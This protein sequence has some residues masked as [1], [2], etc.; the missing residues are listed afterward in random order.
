MHFTIPLLALKLVE[1]K[2]PKDAPALIRKHKDDVFGPVLQKGPDGQKL[3]QARTMD[4]VIEKYNRFISGRIPEI[5][6]K[7][8]LYPME[9]RRGEMHPVSLTKKDPDFEALFR[10]IPAV[11]SVVIFR[12]RAVGLFRQFLGGDQCCIQLYFLDIPD[13]DATGKA[14]DWQRRQDKAKAVYLGPIVCSLDDIQ[15]KGHVSKDGME[16]VTTRVRL[17]TTCISLNPIF[18]GVVGPLWA[19][20]NGQTLLIVAEKQLM[21]PLPVICAASEVCVFDQFTKEELRAFA[22]EMRP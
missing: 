22:Q 11:G 16:L 1:E 12:N 7:D 14:V 3:I 8:Y 13:E 15:W 9:F 19:A 17:G 20:A 10:I 4:D 2:I 5:D 21:R 18:F 6:Q